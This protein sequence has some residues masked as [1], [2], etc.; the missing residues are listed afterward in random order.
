MSHDQSIEELLSA[1]TEDSSEEELLLSVIQAE[2]AAEIA[3]SR[4]AKNLTQKELA[5]ALGVSQ[6]LVSR[7]ENGDVNFTLHTLVRIAQKLD[8]KMISPYQPSRYPKQ[9]ACGNVIS[10]PKKY[11]SPDPVWNVEMVKKGGAIKEM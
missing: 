6:A 1:L 5:D 3:S 2:I 10:F 11:T 9:F 8:I 7:W 4:I